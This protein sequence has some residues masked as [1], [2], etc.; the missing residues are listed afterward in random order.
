MIKGGNVERNIYIHNTVQNRLLRCW[1]IFACG[2][3][4]FTA[5]KNSFLGFIFLSR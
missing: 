1:V 4:P 2:A 3:T 5:M